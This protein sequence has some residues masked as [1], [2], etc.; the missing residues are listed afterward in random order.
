MNVA[1]EF[2]KC[3]MKKQGSTRSQIGRNRYQGKDETSALDS[4]VSYA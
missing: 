4:G 1:P 3:G 2:W